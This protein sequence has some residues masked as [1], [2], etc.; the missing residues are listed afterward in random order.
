M[1]LQP[2]RNRRTEASAA[3]LNNNPAIFEDVFIGPYLDM[4]N[5]ADIPADN[6]GGTRIGMDVDLHYGLTRPSS[7]TTAN[8]RSY[9][10]TRAIGESMNDGSGGSLS[11][12]ERSFLR[13]GQIGA[14][15]LVSDCRPAGSWPET[16]VLYRTRPIWSGR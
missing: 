11:S 14:A 7:C 12:P 2:A 15:R 8:Q 6:L 4:Q 5:L 1:R 10:T 9:I 16:L 3:I 13:R